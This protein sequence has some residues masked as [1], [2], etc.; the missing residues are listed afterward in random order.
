MADYRLTL[1][2]NV[3]R[4]LDGASIPNDPLN[5]D[6]QKYQLWLNNG[7]TPDPVFIPNV[8]TITNCQLKRQLNA[9][10]MLLNAQDLVQKAGGLILELWNGAAFFEITDPLLTSLA[11]SAPPQGLGLTQ[12]QLQQLFN[13]ASKLV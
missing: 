13:D 7:N 11:L 1:G 12:D 10:N 5:V 6:W 4:E 3:I 9:A 2:T 8:T